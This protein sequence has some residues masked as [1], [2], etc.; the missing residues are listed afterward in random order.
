MTLFSA[1]LRTKLGFSIQPA[2]IFLKNFNFYVKK[3]TI[4]AVFAYFSTKYRNF[5]AKFI[6][7][8]AF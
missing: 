6:I 1:T 5:A 2:N 8:Q 3:L 4:L 7:Y